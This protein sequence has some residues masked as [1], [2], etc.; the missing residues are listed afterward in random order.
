MNDT[1]TDPSETA[2]SL[3]PEEARVLGCLL[4][5]EAATPDAYPLS[6][7]SLT[8]AC[9]QKTN[10]NPVVDYGEDDVAEAL[11]G[12]R[13]KG[14]V[15]RVDVSGS[16][17]P[18]Y[19]HRVEERLGLDKPQKAVLAVLLL[20]GPQ[21]LGELR[22]RTE[23]LYSF[24][25]REALQTAIRELNVEGEAPLVTTVP[26]APGQKERRT[27]HLLCGEVEPEPAAAATTVRADE[28][29]E[30]VRERQKRIEALEDRV[31]ELE[32]QVRELREAF[33]SFRQQF[34]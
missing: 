32:T 33:A 5:K 2:S 22:T 29:V 7:N 25:T 20:R 9:N 8:L 12:L 30:R 18:K 28:A 1:P 34:E 3:T 10:R 26:P 15:F 6:L 21:T 27:A 17:V 24:P 11:E 13:G 31:D 16:R 14:L 4:E 19:R 23:R